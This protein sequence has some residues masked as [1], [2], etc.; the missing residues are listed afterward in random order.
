MVFYERFLQKERRQ[1]SI[2][3]VLI[4]AAIAVVWFFAL[5]LWAMTDGGL[6]PDDPAER[7]NLASNL[8][9]TGTALISTVFACLF[10]AVPLTANMYTPQ[11]ISVFVRDRTNCIV[12]G[13]YVFTGATC[14][15]T[16]RL[17]V[18]SDECVPILRIALFLAFSC[19]ILLLPYLFSVFRFLEPRTIVA[20]LHDTTLDAM[21]PSA[22][23]SKA[24]RQEEL[25]QRIRNLGNVILRALERSDREVAL[26]A[27]EALCSCAKHYE[28]VKGKFGNDWFKIGPQHFA[29][30]SKQA[31]NAVLQEKTWVEMEILRQLARAYTSAL[32]KMPDVISAISRS[33]RRF[34]LAAAENNDVGALSLTIKFFNN[35]LREAITREDIHAVFDLV[36]QVRIMAKRLWKNSPESVVDMA[37]RLRYYASMAES[38]EL[39]FARDLIALDLGRVISDVE[40]NKSRL[41]DMVAIWL[42]INLGHKNGKEIISAGIAKARLLTEA[43]MRAQDQ[44]GLA[45]LIRASLVGA[46]PMDWGPIEEEL[47]NDPPKLFWEVTDRQE[48]LSYSDPAHRH[49]IK[50]TLNLLSQC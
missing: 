7:R 35:F 22:T 17:P 24:H 45:D 1:L 36:F 11:L 3:I 29:G 28:K 20:K 18:R 30:F 13:I 40:G 48:N 12:L 26:S 46:Q 10:L 31:M 8:S 50:E 41:A 42:S 38:Q 47:L 14:V 9:R 15:W 21:K 44:T 6:I 2:S 37:R 49:T 34:A 19:L 33:Q 16:A 43:K 23:G 27:V 4:V 5:H 39:P 32:A 25:G